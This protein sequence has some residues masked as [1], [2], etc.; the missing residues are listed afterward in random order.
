MSQNDCHDVECVYTAIFWSFYNFHA[1]RLLEFQN[2]DPFYICTV[3]IDTSW[4]TKFVN[5]VKILGY[6]ATCL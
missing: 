1:R 2:F 5:N 4:V 3:C 6:M